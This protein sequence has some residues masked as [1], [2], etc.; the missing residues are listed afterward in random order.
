MRLVTVAVVIG[1]IPAGAEAGLYYSGEKFAELP[2]QWRG[3]LLDQRMLRMLAV[4]PA[5]AAAAH[6]LR[7]RYLEDLARLEKLAAARKLTA[8]EAADLGAL[9]IRLGDINKALEV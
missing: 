2:S 1:L 5:A 4:K 8:D 9:L 3:F 7:A 6:P